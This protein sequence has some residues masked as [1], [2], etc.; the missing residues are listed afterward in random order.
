MAIPWLALSLIRRSYRDRAKQAVVHQSF[1][2]LSVDDVRQAAERFADEVVET[3][4]NPKIADRIDAHRSQGHELV[5]ATATAVVAAEPIA[6]R[7]GIHRTIATDLAVSSGTYTGG[8]LGANV[9]DEEKLRRVI[10]ALGRAP[11]YAYG[12]LPDDE[13]M[14]RASDEAWVVSAGS[15][16]PY[17]V[18]HS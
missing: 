15:V 6:Q 14:L 16:A 8:L 11:D 12:N 3:G 9:R 5:M 7:L 4:I 2:G 18:S 17:E 13:P 1:R 10:D